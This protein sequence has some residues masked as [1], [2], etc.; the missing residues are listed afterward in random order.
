MFDGSKLVPLKQHK[1]A[2]RFRTQK[3][4]NS[5]NEYKGTDLNRI[6]P[7]NSLSPE[8]LES[9]STNKF[10]NAVDQIGKEHLLVSNY[11]SHNSPTTII[12]LSY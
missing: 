11:Y 5:Q 1:R 8:A 12:V 7:W 4:I 2:H 3:R 10:K 9:P 6:K